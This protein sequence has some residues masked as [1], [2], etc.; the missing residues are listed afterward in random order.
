VAGLSKELKSLNFTRRNPR[1]SAAAPLAFGAAIRT[2][3]ITSYVPSNANNVTLLADAV[4]ECQKRPVNAAKPWSV[5]EVRWIA[6]IV[7]AW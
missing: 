2:R 3:N 1:R 7:L 6:G 4:R 5:E